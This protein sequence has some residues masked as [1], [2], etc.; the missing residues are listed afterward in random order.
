MGRNEDMLAL[1]KKGQAYV[2]IGR[3]Y[4]ISK[5]RVHMICK[6]LGFTTHAYVLSKQ[7][8]DGILK[9]IKKR[10]VDKSKSIM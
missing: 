2:E 9:G 4:G 5:Q 1:R 10:V 7:G 3:L 6:K 8:R